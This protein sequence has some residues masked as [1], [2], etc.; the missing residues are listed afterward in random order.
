MKIFDNDDSRKKI[1]K[2]QLQKQY[3]K[4]CNYIKLEQYHKV[5]LKLRKPKKLEIYQFR[6]TRK[7]RAFA[8]KDKFGLNV[9]HISEHQ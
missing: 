8:F 4:S 9:F 7:Y 2:Y 3:K 1:E 6:I 5:Q